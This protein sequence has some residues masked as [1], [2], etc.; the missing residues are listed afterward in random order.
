M[1]TALIIILVVGF[2]PLIIAILAGLLMQENG[3]SG[4]S[5]GGGCS[6]PTAVGYVSSAA[7]FVTVPLGAI[8]LVAWSV[9]AII[10]AVRDR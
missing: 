4:I 9:I 3:C 2:G 8:A 6:V 5:T 1:R 7:S 10:R